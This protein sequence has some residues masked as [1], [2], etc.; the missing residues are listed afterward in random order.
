MTVLSRPAH[1]EGLQSLAERYDLVLC[2]VW[3]VLH[4]GV[5]AYEAASDALKRFRTEQTTSVLDNPDPREA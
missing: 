1:V 5:K 4:N 3:G 2:D